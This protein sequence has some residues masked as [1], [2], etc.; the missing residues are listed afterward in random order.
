MAS[1]ASRPG[2]T[3]ALTPSPASKAGAHL[4]AGEGQVLTVAQPQSSS[5]YVSV[6][7]TVANHGATNCTSASPAASMASV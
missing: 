5:T 3:A 4:V 7:T 6:P 1:A 2:P